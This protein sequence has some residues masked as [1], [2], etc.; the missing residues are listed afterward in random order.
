MTVFETHVRRILVASAAA[1]L[2]AAAHAGDWYPLQVHATAPDGSVKLIEYQAQTKA[3][4]PWQICVSFP[5]MKDPFFLAANYGVIEEAKRLGVKVQ[6]LDAGGY[7][8]LSQQI[9]QVQN[10]VVGGAN[11]VVLTAISRE[12][13]GNLLNALKQKNVKVVDAIN[14]VASDDVAARVLT[15]PYDEALHI[16]QYMAR[17]HPAGSKPVK[18]GWFPG[19]AGAGFVTAFTSGLM[20][21]IKGSAVQVVATMHGDVGKEVQARLVEN[22]LQSQKDLDYIVGTAVTVEAAIPLIHAHHLAGK[23]RLVSLYAT[24]GVLRGVKSGEIEAMHV[25]PVVSTARM[26][27]DTAV[28]VLQNKQ[29]EPLTRYDTIGRVYTAKDIGTLDVNTVLAPQG[30]KPVFRYAPQ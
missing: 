19:P 2:V 8:E 17:E 9:S 23:V 1:G 18:V 24:P 25:S 16:G 28:R 26:T 6:V 22:M 3:E 30:F 14:G 7:T 20:D 12:S 4:R 27:V 15:S 10:C 29:P 21:G 11:A 13:M 5:H